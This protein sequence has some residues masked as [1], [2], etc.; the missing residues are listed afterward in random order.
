LSG[1]VEQRKPQVKY[2]KLGV[3]LTLQSA[4]LE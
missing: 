1:T 2:D 4:R 3:F